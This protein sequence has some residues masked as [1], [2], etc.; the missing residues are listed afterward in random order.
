MPSGAS[1][2]TRARTRWP[3]RSTSWQECTKPRA[4]SPARTRAQPSGSASVAVRASSETTSP[5]TSSPTAIAVVGVRVL[6]AERGQ[7]AA[8]GLALAA[9]ERVDARMLRGAVGEREA[10]V[11]DARGAAPD[12]EL[13]AEHVAQRVGGLARLDEHDL[14]A[15]AEPPRERARLDERA[16]VAGRDHDLGQLALRRQKPE[17]DVLAH[18]LRWQPHVELVRGPCRHARSVSVRFQSRLPTS[19]ARARRRASRAASRRRARSITSGG[20]SL[21]TFMPS[22]VGCTIAPRSRRRS[23]IA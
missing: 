12:R 15:A 5:S 23:Q 18:L 17:M 14:R 9:L 7:Q 13:V 8:L 3:M 19:R 20:L 21:S 2:R 22:P 11:V 6:D 16:P 4:R 10:R 1:S